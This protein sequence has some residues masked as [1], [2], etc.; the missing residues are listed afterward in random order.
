MKRKYSVT[1]LYRKRNLIEARLNDLV[2]NGY[3]YIY[4]YNNLFNLNI[5]NV[6]FVETQLRRMLI[7][8]TDAFKGKS[9]NKLKIM[10]L[11]G[12]GLFSLEVQGSETTFVIRLLLFSKEE[13]DFNSF[14]NEY[15]GS[16]P[17][18]KSIVSYTNLIEINHLKNV[19][20]NTFYQSI[21]NHDYARTLLIDNG[22]RKR[23]I[24]GLFGQINQKAT[25]HDKYK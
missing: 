12:G 20:N 2:E 6:E 9:Y 8:R 3:K 11:V 24:I 14:N 19:L 18:K 10:S 5:G 25:H 13:I 1:P 23:T 16:N 21:I 4:S 7:H 15:F 17:V 22:Y